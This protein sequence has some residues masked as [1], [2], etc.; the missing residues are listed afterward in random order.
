MI[1]VDNERTVVVGEMCKVLGDL[2]S[3]MAEIRN[4]FGKDYTKEDVDELLHKAV[5]LSG[6]SA[7]QLLEYLSEQLKELFKDE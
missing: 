6:K 5:D 7:E 4:A 3:A 1:I 2:T